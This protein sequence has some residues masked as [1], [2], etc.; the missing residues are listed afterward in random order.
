MRLDMPPVRHPATK[1]GW[2]TELEADLPASPN[3]ATM[4]CFTNH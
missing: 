2:M 3:P 4:A 1:P